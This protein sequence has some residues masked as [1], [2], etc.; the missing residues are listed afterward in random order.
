MS[1]AV[2]QSY[3]IHC[4]CEREI[5]SIVTFNVE[6]YSISCRSDFFPLFVQFRRSASNVKTTAET[7]PFADFIWFGWSL[8]CWENILL[9][10][11]CQDLDLDCVLTV[12]FECIKIR[13]ILIH[14]NHFTHTITDCVPFSSIVRNVSSSIDCNSMWF[15]VTNE[16]YKQP[17]CRLWWFDCKVLSWPNSM[18]VSF[19]W[20]FQF[21]QTHESVGKK[22]NR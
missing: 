12:Y 18:G 4:L 6:L 21:S 9:R 7:F 5:D 1:F 10:R 15:K 2:V 16:K 8:L 11:K 3:Y 17:A 20:F 22:I 13:S 19:S 14:A